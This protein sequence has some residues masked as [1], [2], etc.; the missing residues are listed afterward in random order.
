MIDIGSNFETINSDKFS[1]LE[2]FRSKF[3]D[4][5]N[6]GADLYIP[7]PYEIATII[8]WVEYFINRMRY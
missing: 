1:S 6:S 3:E 7:K 4:L 2:E 8:K 5:E